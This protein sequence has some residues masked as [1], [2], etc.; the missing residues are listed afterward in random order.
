MSSGVYKRTKEHLEQMKRN[1]YQKGNKFG[2]KKGYIPK[3]AFKKGSIPWSKGKKCPQLS[4]ENNSQWK[5]GK[6]IN[7]GYVLIFK[8]RHPFCDHR[9]YVREHRLIIE[10]QIGRFLFPEEECHHINK[11]KGD[12]R[13][14]N[15]MVFVNKSAHLRFEGKG[16]IKS[17]EIIFDGRKL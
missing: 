2:F 1:G 16:K 14:Q 13:P 9:R 4:G 8:P 17:K 11:I 15:L 6:H 10:K 5:G 3:N 7:N 12:N